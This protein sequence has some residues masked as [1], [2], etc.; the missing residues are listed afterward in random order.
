[1][2]ILHVV[3]T[4]LPATRYGG[5][6]VSVHGLARAQ[7]ELG[8]QVSVATTSVDGAQDSAVAHGVPVH[9]D[10]VS[11]YYFRSRWLRRIYF[12]PAMRRFLRAELKGFD[13]VHLHSVF[14][15]PTNM[16]ARECVR[17]GVPYVLAPRGMLVESL[18][19][20]K[21]AW[22]KR[23]WLRLIEGFTLRHASMFHAT[24]AREVSDAQALG[25][26]VRNP[27]VIANGVEP[28]PLLARVEPE[29][30]YALFLG[31]IN[32]KKRIELLIDA[33]AEVPGLDLK[34]AGNDEE[35]LL[36]T[37]QARIAAAGLESRVRF[38]GTVDG[39]AKQALLAQARVLV[40]PSLSENFGN[41]VL[42]AFNQG[43]PVIVAGG[44]GLA[45]I[46]ADAQAGWVFEQREELIAALNAA[47]TDKAAASLR[48]V[49]GRQ[50]VESQFSW[51]EIA[52][53]M[54]LAYR[55]AGAP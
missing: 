32:W 3:P 53:Q 11:V 27:Q 47:S 34:I 13:V 16:A 25:V 36:P 46:V 29:P 14:L 21:S 51:P 43:C 24:S 4:Y 22:V 30:P 44:V 45:P 6:I 48:G 15:W 31:R 7:A 19:A 12:A 20:Q 23:L 42:E 39:A 18:I 38:V 50:L 17:S 52:R 54:R 35:N 2:R 49:R 33:L 28:N 10:G 37:L 40:L 26:C 1:M 5:P 9:L 41:V 8:D 55:Q